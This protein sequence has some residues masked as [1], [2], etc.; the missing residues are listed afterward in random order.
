MI[1]TENSEYIQVHYP[2]N[3]KGRSISGHPESPAQRLNN[4]MK[5]N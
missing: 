5:F 2:D 3:L 4:L 1:N